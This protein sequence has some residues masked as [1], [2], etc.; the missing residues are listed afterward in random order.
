MSEAEDGLQLRNGRVVV[1]ETLME[2]SV[3]DGER[4]DNVE[5]MH[6]HVHELE[7]KLAM[8]EQAVNDKDE[9]LLAMR[10]ALENAKSEAATDLT[11]AREE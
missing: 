5:E 7:Q 9:E 10:E 6:S 4:T 3:S 1:T 11:L 8:A 2:E